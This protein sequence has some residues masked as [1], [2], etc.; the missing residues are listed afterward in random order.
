MIPD[1][2]LILQS[3]IMRTAERELHRAVTIK[4]LFPN[5]R[6]QRIKLCRT[7]K[8]IPGLTGAS[9]WL[10]IDRPPAFNSQVAQKIIHGLHFAEIVTMKHRRYLRFQSGIL[11]G[12][13][14]ANRAPSGAF[15]S[16]QQIM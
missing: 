1:H 9:D 8:K 2:S 13:D 10:Y 12:T 7:Q 3:Q 5:K 15:L 4:A 11:Q 6:K 14:S 16:S